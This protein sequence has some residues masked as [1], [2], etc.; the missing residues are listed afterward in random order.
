MTKTELESLRT[1]IEGLL[2]SRR[3]IG[4]FDANSQ[5]IRMILECQL[6]MLEHL[7]NPKGKP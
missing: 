5:V 6:R 4:D 7:I 2:L 3:K 1:T